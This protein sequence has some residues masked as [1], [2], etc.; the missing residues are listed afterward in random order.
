MS[1]WI[2]TSDTPAGATDLEYSYYPLPA[3]REQLTRLERS[4]SREELTEL[5]AV[6]DRYPLTLTLVGT[7]AVVSLG[8][9]LLQF[10]AQGLSLLAFLVVILGL[11]RLDQSHGLDR[12]FSSCARTD[13]VSLRA[14]HRA[15]LAVSTARTA[16]PIARAWSWTRGGGKR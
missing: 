2:K 9:V 14:G 10:V 5:S 15:H 4:L 6:R 16:G 3:P 12:T 7:S 1:P 8:L 13:C 11:L